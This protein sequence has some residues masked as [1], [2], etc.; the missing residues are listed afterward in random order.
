MT[1]VPP[2]VGLVRWQF[3]ISIVEDSFQDIKQRSL[4]D[5]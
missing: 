1:P 3:Y 4:I 5:D 2:F